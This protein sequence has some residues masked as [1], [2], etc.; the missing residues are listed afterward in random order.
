[1][2]IEVGNMSLE[3]LLH[4]QMLRGQLSMWHLSLGKDDPRNFWYKGLSVCGL[5]SV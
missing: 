4:G 2:N 3:Q 1:M 5:H